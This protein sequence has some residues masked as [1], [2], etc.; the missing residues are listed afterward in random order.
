MAEVLTAESAAKSS[1][2]AVLV[3]KTPSIV[4]LD[5]KKFEDF[6]DEIRRECEAH[7]PDLS[8]EKGRKAIASLAYKVARTK[9]A[10][11]D[12]GKALNEDARKQISVVDA[13]RKTIR[14]RLD[15]LKDQVRKPL[16]DWETAEKA[17]KDEVFQRIE[18]YRDAGNVTIVDSSDDISAQLEK[19]RAETIDPDVFR[20]DTERA[21]DILAAT[22]RTLEQALERVRQEEADRA[23]LER[24]RQEQARRDEEDRIARENAREAEERAA[25]ER[26]AAE[27]VERAR[28]E[29]AEAAARKAEQKAREEQE[30]RDWAHQEELEA[31]RR[32]ADHLAAQEESAAEEKRRAA[33][34]EHRRIVLTEAMNAIMQA[35]DIGEDQARSVVLAISRGNIPHVS[36]GF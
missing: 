2:I 32:R 7:E 30:A 24:L 23:E 17:R 16:T 28:Q 13:A 3:E 31:E 14:D 4:L 5:A 36:I 18:I 35:G 33:D 26:E 12:A 20:E 22:I 6:Y 1:D 10:I 34:R 25:R 8:T 9:T 19:M 11:D 21:G 29:A 27:R 15:A